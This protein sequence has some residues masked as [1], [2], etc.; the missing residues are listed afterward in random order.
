MNSF[1]DRREAGRMLAARLCE[2]A[3]RSDAIILALPRGGIP[4]AYEIARA[5]R[6]PLDVF[7]VRKVY[8]PGRDDV[9]VGTITS[10]GYEVLEAET[11]AARGVDR[12]IV[13]R[14]MARARQD[15]AYQERVYRG[16]RR[17]PDVAGRTVILVYDGIVTGGSMVTA[18]AALRAN[19][20]ARVVVAAPVAAPNARDA[21]ARVADAVVCVVTPEPFYRIGIWYDD[22][23]PVSDAS[24]L[25]LLDSAARELSAVAA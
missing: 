9:Q 5:L 6:L 13:D 10:G 1:L 2:Y 8:E 15:L 21:V 19:G 7:L 16:T 11:I 14:E 12:H 4:V 18:V 17:G 23:A 20:A 3:H 22:F 24:V 25:L